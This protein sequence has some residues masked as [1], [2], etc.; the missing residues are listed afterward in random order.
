MRKIPIFAIGLVIFSALYTIFALRIPTRQIRWDPGGAFL[1][2]WLGF[3]MIILSSIYLFKSLK[4]SSAGKFLSSWRILLGLIIATILYVVFLRYEFP[5]AS[6]AYS[7]AIT[8][9]VASNYKMKINNLIALIL[10]AIFVFF[11]CLAFW[12]LKVEFP[13]ILPL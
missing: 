5:I 1:P 10:N 6:L 8:K 2:I 7:F 13:T 4:I 12:L 9:M 11:L 3:I